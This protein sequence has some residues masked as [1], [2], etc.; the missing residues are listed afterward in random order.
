[1][2]K[3]WFRYRKKQKKTSQIFA[4]HC[5]SPYTATELNFALFHLVS[6][7]YCKKSFLTDSKWRVRVKMAARFQ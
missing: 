3:Y 1:M 6:Q 5:V 4:F 2:R 7:N